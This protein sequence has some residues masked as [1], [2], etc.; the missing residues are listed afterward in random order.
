MEYQS[1]GVGIIGKGKVQRITKRKGR[2]ALAF[3][4]LHRAERSGAEQSNY[5]H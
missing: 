2:K 3:T 5:C 4:D 1:D